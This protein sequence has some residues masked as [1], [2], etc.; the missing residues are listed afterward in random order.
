MS[1]RSEP[2]Q[3]PAVDLDYWLL[4]RGLAEHRRY[5]RACFHHMAGLPAVGNP[6]LSVSGCRGKD[7]RVGGRIF[8]HSRRFRVK[9]SNRIAD[10]AGVI[11]APYLHDH[12]MVEDARRITEQFGLSYRIGDPGDDWYGVG[13]TPLVIWNPGKISL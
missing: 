11:T 10:Y 12:E 7:C 6:A 1:K 9:G 2:G 4:S 13:T 5:D 8:D 3:L